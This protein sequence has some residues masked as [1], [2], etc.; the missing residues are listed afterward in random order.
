M[1]RVTKTGS[2]PGF[3]ADWGSVARNSGRQ[4]DWTRLGLSYEGTRYTVKAAAAAAIGAVAITVDPL[5]VALPLGTILNFG[6]HPQVTVTINDGSI[7]AGDTSITVTALPGAIPS[8]ARLNFSGG[9]N[10]QLVEVNGD[11]AAG[12]TTLTVLP[13]DGT[14]ANS[15][16]AVFEGGTIQARLTAP[17]AK[18]ATSLTVD[19]LQFVVADDAEAIYSPGG[20]KVIKSGTVMAELSSGKIIPRKAVTGSETAIGFLVG[21]AE[22][23]AKQDA[24][25]GFG[26]IIGGVVYEDL[27]PDRDESGFATWIGEIRTAGSQLRLETYSD[28]RAS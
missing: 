23:D 3:V 12:A 26:L 5:P 18:G 15:A 1:G 21:D 7:S 14:I 28:S 17:A 19:D 2:S 27:L 6:E 13:V 24:L 4:I 8:G 22:E 20:S 10:A 9:T 25:S 16:T 11:H